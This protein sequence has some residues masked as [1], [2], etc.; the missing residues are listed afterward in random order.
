VTPGRWVV[1]G[2]CMTALVYTVAGGA[3]I[4]LARRA[5]T[6]A[7]VS[8]TSVTGRAAA[9]A[10]DSGIFASPV[11]PLGVHPVL[12]H[13][14]AE[15]AAVAEGYQFVP[16]YQVAGTPYYRQH[17]TERRHF[18]GRAY[19]V[20]PVMV[21]PDSV[22]HI[23]ARNDVVN[24][25]GA[26]WVMAVCDD[27]GTARTLVLFADEP[28]RL[29]VIQGDQ[30]GDVPE[31]VRP[32]DQLGRIF[33]AK[34]RAT[35][36][37][38]NGIALTPETAVIFATAQLAG[39]GARVAEV[40]EA[41]VVAIHTGARPGG[42]GPGTFVQ[43]YNCP[44][45]RLTLDRLVRLRG[46]TSGQVVNTRT[47]YVVRGTDGCRGALAVQIPTPAQPTTVPFTYPVPLRAPRHGVLSESGRRVEY[48]TPELRV[49]AWRV[50]EPLW[51]E[52][53]RLAH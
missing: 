20:R 33:G 52:E 32:P 28:T 14:D 23:T 9:A 43:P 27:A 16:S 34:I 22:R 8:L 46:M 31:L 39:A 38:E 21:L 37:M 5:R 4:G 35:R 18:C 50:A 24:A 1:Y 45:W 40:P 15:S 2:A 13:A 47:V 12:A 29:H 44:R 19:Y 42:R 36:D 7:R 30:P 11:L 17:P 26:T 3:A 51:F 25:W 49:A 10:G 53:A 48:P 6:A 41:F